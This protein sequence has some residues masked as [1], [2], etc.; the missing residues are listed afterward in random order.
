MS[1]ENTL[2]SALNELGQAFEAFK[3]VNDERL[4]ALEDKLPFDGVQEDK[5]Q[6][7][8]HVMDQAQ[9]T[10]LQMQ[11][12][13][14]RRP[15]LDMPST[16]SQALQHKNAFLSYVCSGNTQAL[17]RMESKALNHVT[18]SEG[19]FLMPKSM[20]ETLYSNLI[21]DSLLRKLPTMV[22]VKKGRALDIILDEKQGV[23]V[24]WGEEKLKAPSLEDV[25]SSLKKIHIPLCTMSQRPK[26]TQA[27]LEEGVVNIESW[28]LE[29]ARLKMMDAEN[30]AFLYGDPDK[31][32]PEG[33]VFK[34][35]S[36]GIPKTVLDGDFPSSHEQADK[37][38]STI[39]SKVPTYFLRD[40]VW[41]GSKEVMHWARSIK[42]SQGYVFWVPTKL[43]E[44]PILMGYEFFVTDLMEQEKSSV[45]LMFGSFKRGYQGIYREGIRLIRDPFTYKPHVE[46][47][48][49]AYIGGAVIH[50][51]AFSALYIQ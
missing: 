7:L 3:E 31:H 9:V 40:S 32:Q 51:K 37:I 41:I 28:L 50:P 29:E 15:I 18:D 5:L 10:M 21:E 1:I 39:L 34:A 48:M 12:T 17:R 35:K 36:G 45:P 22:E 4:K 27:L 25:D 13:V 16:D 6:R 26:V 19:G 44:K 46:L 8:Q 2:Q 20:I 33:V 38:L 24:V 47:Y 42:T 23:P 30:H 49:M 11:N 14:N 43:H